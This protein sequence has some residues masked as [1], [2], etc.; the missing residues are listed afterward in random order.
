MFIGHF[1][2]G[3]AS[4]RVAPRT[5]LGTLILAAMFLDALWPVFLLLGLERVRIDPGNMVFSPLAFD[6]YPFSHSLLMT[7]VWALLFALIYRAR[8]GYENGAVWVGIGVTSHWI[9]DFVTH[10]PDLPLAPG[11]SIKVGL[12][13]WNSRLGTLAVE[14]AM[15]VAAVTLYLVTTRARNRIGRFALWGFVAILAALYVADANSPPP[16]SVKAIAITGLIG[17]LFVPWAY[18]IDRNREGAMAYSAR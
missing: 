16:P 3:F 18:W 2:V 6:Y 15:Y 11:S 5:S 9:L 12:G 7:I 10:R 4:K 17:W 13:L 14:G 8:T 1:A